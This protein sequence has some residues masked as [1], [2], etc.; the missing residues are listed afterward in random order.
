MNLL[1][2]LRQVSIFALVTTLTAFVPVVAAALYAVRPS[3]RR[4]A[5]MRPFSLAALFGTLASTF[6]GFVTIAQDIAVSPNVAWGRVAG[7]LSEALVPLV[8]GFTCLTLAWLLVAV[9]MR[10]GDS[11]G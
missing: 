4:L 10:R 7:G 5:L 8:L 3:E 11:E 1:E 6:S 9:G 2:L